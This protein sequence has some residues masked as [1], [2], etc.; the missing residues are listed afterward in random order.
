MSKTANASQPTAASPDTARRLAELGAK[1]QKLLQDNLQNLG[2]IWS[3]PI[4]PTPVWKA[5]GD[6][7]IHL[8]SDPFYLA[9]EQFGLWQEYAGLWRQMAQRMLGQEP[10][11]AA[12]PARGDRRFKHAAWNDELVFHYLKQSY[13]IGSRWLQNLVANVKGL[14]PVTQ[15]TVEFATK[16]YVDALSPSNFALT[17]PE[18]IK[19]AVDTGGES[20][21]QGL[22]NFLEDIAE[23]RG[24]VK[25]RGPEAFELGRNIA[26]TPG[27]VIYQNDLMQLIQYAPA[28]E[29][30][31]RRPL[32]LV[33]PWVNKFYLFDLKPD[34]SFINWLVGKGFT[35]F[36]LSWVNPSATHAAKDF[37]N[38]MTEGPLAALDAIE[39]AIG[40]RDAN[41]VGYCLGGTLTAAT[42]AH[43]AAK[44][45]DRVKS[46]TLIATMTDFR[47]LGEFAAIINDQQLQAIDNYTE[48]KGYVEGTELAHLFSLIRANDLIWSNVVSHYLLAEEAVP[49]DMLFWFADPV[50]MPGKMIRT[51]TRNIVLKNALT[52]PG[53]LTLNGTPI[54]LSAVKEPVCF[55]SLKEDHVAGWEATYAGTKLFGGPVRFV[56]GG[57]GYNAGVINPPKANK[58]GYWTND[59]LPPTAEEW[60]AGA[61]RH[62][63]S[64]WPEWAA[65]VKQFSGDEIPSRQIG[66]GKLKPSEPAPGSYALART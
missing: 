55:I 2:A 34:N 62:E 10:V 50:G 13:L 39:Q 47:D 65:W 44:G 60:L 32:L 57:S 3:G 27:S 33:P 11:A 7:S 59:S 4:D 1:T 16:Q 23:N 40:E 54:H 36:A 20:L 58:H 43:M 41:L 19:K 24:L 51:Y 15:R 22:Y 30:T 45:D 42:L 53:A 26:A 66:A 52:H 63:G 49:S 64:W 31:F 6:L 37:E 29:K 5:F 21:L 38:Y 17:N 61:T 14:D 8:A 9:Q 18:V 56:L 48:R 12:G 25:R 46:A 28:T 35:V